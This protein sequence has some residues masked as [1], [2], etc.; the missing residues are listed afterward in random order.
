MLAKLK[1]HIESHHLFNTQD[2]LL[3]GVSAGVDSMVLAHLL[4]ELPFDFFIAHMNFGLRG[5][6]SDLDADF[7]EQ[8]GRSQGIIT[9]ILKVNT[10]VYA[11]KNQ[12][13][14]QMAARSLRYDWFSEL[15]SLHKYSAILTAHHAD[16]NL[17]TVL[18]NLTKGTGIRG[19]R[20]M[21]I[22]QGLLA[23]PL[24]IFG[25]QEIINYAQKQRMAWREDASNVSNKYT[26]NKIRNEILP[27]LKEINPSV[28]Q[29]F[30][31]TQARLIS[32]EMLLDQKVSDL[33]AQY[34]KSGP[35]DCLEVSW[36][37]DHPLDHLLLFE[38]LESYELG[39]AQFKQIFRS[40]VQNHSA[41]F[42]WNEYQLNVD[43]HKVWIGKTD[44]IIDPAA[45]K[46]ITNALEVVEFYDY[47]LTFN[48]VLPSTDSIDKSLN[49]ACLD[50]E[51]LTFPLTLRKWKKGDYFYPLGMT[52]K[53]K[54][55]DFLVDQK[56]PRI[57]KESLLILAS[58]QKICWLVGL[59]ID[60]RFRL[61]NSTKNILRVEMKDLKGSEVNET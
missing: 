52:Q 48:T 8:W 46:E 43:R 27:V 23:R 55:S 20:G 34:F 51:K 7:V 33:K 3:L 60:D 30:R 41:M 5:Q 40:V 38:L 28:L 36:V 24:L 45:C 15:A 17:E 58:K 4:K 22:Q 31:D 37:R 25:K 10:E 12:V 18:F 2:R 32:S 1:A 14:T 49:I 26:R 47:Q 6:E 50:R 16:D 53:K 42:Y 35:I 59:R 13:S 29:T 57:K 44:R 9:H 61:K 21:K 39:Y 11:K 56:I 19:L 54:V